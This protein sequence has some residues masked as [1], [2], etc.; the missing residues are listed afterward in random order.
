MKGDVTSTLHANGR[1]NFP[2]K[3]R[4]GLGDSFVIA[5]GLDVPCIQVYSLAAWERFEENLLEKN[6]PLDAEQL[7]RFMSKRNEE[8]DKQGRFFVP[9]HLREY[10]GLSKE[11]VFNTVGKKVEI[12]SKEAWD[13]NMSEMNVKSLLGKIVF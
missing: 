2:S 10:A 13:S 9:E 4:E 6:H 11:V 1:V 3:L 12:W 8:I 7:L 5:K